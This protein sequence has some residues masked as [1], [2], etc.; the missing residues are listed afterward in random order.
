VVAGAGGLLTIL[1]RPLARG[2]AAGLLVVLMACQATF[3]PWYYGP[4]PFLMLRTGLLRPVERVPALVGAAPL[5]VAVDDP[6]CNLWA[7]YFL[8]GHP[9]YFSEYRSYMKAVSHLPQGTDPAGTRWLLTDEAFDGKVVK[10]PGWRLAWSRGPYRLW[11]ADAPD[12]AVLSDCEHAGGPGPRL[13]PAADG[14]VTLDALTNRDGTLEITGKLAVWDRPAEEG[15]VTVHVRLENGHEY[16]GTCAGGVVHLTVPVK[17]GKNRV[18]LHLPAPRPNAAP[19]ASAAAGP[20]PGL[21]EVTLQ[22]WARRPS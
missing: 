15:P 1:R 20:R 21:E 4:S 5:A 18:V 12:W 3:A 6:N 11:H 10:G 2:L 22:M 7:V 13:A 17:C 8:R 19:A 9:C 14:L 16:H